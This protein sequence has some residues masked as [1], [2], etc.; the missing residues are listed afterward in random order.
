MRKI[1]N[2][3][4]FIMALFL[5]L[6]ILACEDEQAGFTKFDQSYV[7]F[8]DD[9]ASI[10]ESQ[11][12]TTADGQSVTGGSTYTVEL[13]R[14]SADLS[15]PVTVGISVTTVFTD[16]TDFTLPGDDASDQFIIEDVSSVTIPAGEVS[17]SFLVVT[18][19]D[20]SASGNKQV[21]LNIQDVSD[22]SYQVGIGAGE[23]RRRG[24]L[25]LVVVDDDCPVNTADFEGAYSVTYTRTRDGRSFT[26]DAVIKA[27]P[28]D[29]KRLIIEDYW[30]QSGSSIYVV[31]DPCPET[32]A[33][34]KQDFAADLYGYGQSEVRQVGLGSYSPISNGLTFTTKITVS[35]G[36]FGNWEGVFS[37]K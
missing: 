35:A 14:S 26:A 37:K 15:N 34:P 3:Y 1:H 7:A 16:S 20:K 32:V 10:S 23:N 25:N 6:G 4:T 30:G 5:S 28:T 36:S 33:V 18:K 2:K 19:N 9:A 31:L 27:D 11:A 12:V 24:E 17:T 29:D 21:T 13:I 22:P 8:S